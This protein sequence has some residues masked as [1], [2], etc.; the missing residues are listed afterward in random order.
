MPCLMLNTPRAGNSTC[1]HG[2]LDLP[3]FSHKNATKISTQFW[4]DSLP[5][6]WEP[7]RTFD[8][9]GM[10]RQLSRIISKVPG[11]PRRS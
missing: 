6:Y 1:P 10:P 9:A 8:T 2:M 7:L 5:S 4:Q 11:L 3:F